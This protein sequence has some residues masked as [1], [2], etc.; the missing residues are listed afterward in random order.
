[1]APFLRREA[2]PARIDKYYVLS[3]WESI[4]PAI[5]TLAVGLRVYLRRKY[6]IALGWDDLSIV[7]SIVGSAILLV[8]AAN[9][10]IAICMGKLGN[11]LL[12]LLCCRAQWH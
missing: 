5:A 12:Y 7:A 8:D 6:N 9:D 4:F 2:P 1:M 10:H 11:F 3:C